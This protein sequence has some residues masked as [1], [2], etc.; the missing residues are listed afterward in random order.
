MALRVRS[1]AWQVIYRCTARGRVD[2]LDVAKDFAREVA[3]DPVHQRLMGGRLIFT[4]HH[5]EGKTVFEI[6]EL[7]LRIGEVE[8]EIGYQRLVAIHSLEGPGVIDELDGVFR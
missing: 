5:V 6:V 1:N 2:A 3:T 7:P 8:A 4:V